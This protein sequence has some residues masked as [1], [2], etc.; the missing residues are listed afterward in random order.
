MVCFNSLPAGFKGKSGTSIHINEPG[1]A[2]L[3]GRPGTQGAPGA[4]GPP[5][6]PGSPGLHFDT[7]KPHF[8]SS[9]KLLG[10]F[11]QMNIAS[12]AVVV[13]TSFLL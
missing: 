8:F 7:M 4:N 11:F 2:G 1:P 6:I 9:L 10:F 13:R 3:S 5:G 12:K